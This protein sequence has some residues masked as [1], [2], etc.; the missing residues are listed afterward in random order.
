MGSTAWKWT[1]DDGAEGSEHDFC[2]TAEVAGFYLSAFLVLAH[3]RSVEL[4]HDERHASLDDRGA[5]R[6]PGLHD[7]RRWQT[8][9]HGRREDHPMGQ[10]RYV[11]RSDV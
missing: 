6:V 10:Q 4:E 2:S 5:L 11:P 1:I 7:R 3:Y 9:I 8:Q